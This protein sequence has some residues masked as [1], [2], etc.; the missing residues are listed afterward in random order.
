ME[1]KRFTTSFLENKVQD[2][3]FLS[4]YSQSNRK[5]YRRFFQTA[6]SHVHRIKTSPVYSSLRFSSEKNI[7]SLPSSC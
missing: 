2:G 4:L 7:E 6:M 1:K 3:A 5:K